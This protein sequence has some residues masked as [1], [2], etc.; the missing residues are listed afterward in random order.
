MGEDR[1]SFR[2]L[3]IQSLSDDPATR[4]RIMDIFENYKESANKDDIVYVLVI[5]QELT[6]RVLELIHV[7]QQQSME[8]MGTR[9]SELLEQHRRIMT[10]TVLRQQIVS[11]SQ[12][13]RMFAMHREHFIDRL[14]VVCA[15]TILS[16][17]AGLGVFYLYAFWG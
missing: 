2:N 15:L 16:V 11:R 8:L 14:I 10:E 1:L 13:R 5:E 17:F 9:I 7:R 3:A 12:F 6:H 4:R